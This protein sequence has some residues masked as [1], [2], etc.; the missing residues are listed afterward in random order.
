[1][2]FLTKLYYMQQSLSSLF[3]APSK[4]GGRGVFTS[5]AISKGSIIEISPVIVMPK[6]DRKHMDD[7]KLHDYYF[8]W[9]EQDDQ[10][11]IVLGY[12]S[13]Y[14]HAYT[15]NAEYAPDFKSATLDF[16]ALFDI[17]AGEEITVNYSGDPSGHIPLWFKDKK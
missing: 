7:T 10:C 2:L 4:L 15:P 1:M 9:G 12:G 11:A 8:I 5:K 6:K 14:N 17:K 16:Y 3:I 13:L